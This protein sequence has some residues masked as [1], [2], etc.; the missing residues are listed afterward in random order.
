MRIH[1]FIYLY[2][3]SAFDCTVHIRISVHTVRTLHDYTT[4]S[5]LGLTTRI[6]LII[7]NGVI[8]ELRGIFVN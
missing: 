4:L 2:S 7:N 5:N 8:P 6:F 3:Q 1:I